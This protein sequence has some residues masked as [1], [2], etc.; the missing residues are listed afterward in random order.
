MLT[1]ETVSNFPLEV[2]SFIE[3]VIVVVELSLEC[4]DRTFQAESAWLFV[5]WMY[6]GFA[7]T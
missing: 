1:K 7:G 4:G 6:Y 2:E 3:E 5:D